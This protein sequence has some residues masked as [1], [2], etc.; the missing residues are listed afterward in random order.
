MYK[1]ACNAAS[2]CIYIRTQLHKGTVIFFLNAPRSL[3][4]GRVLDQLLARWIK[5]EGNFSV[6]QH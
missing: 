2:L 3:K 5:R 1:T 4:T 6:S